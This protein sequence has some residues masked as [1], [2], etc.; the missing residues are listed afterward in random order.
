MVLSW[1]F[2][3]RSLP[4]IFTK[5]YLHAYIEM[6]G[7]S[8]VMDFYRTIID[9]IDIDERIKNELIEPFN[10]YITGKKDTIGAL[11]YNVIALIEGGAYQ[12]FDQ[13]ESAIINITREVGRRWC[14]TKDSLSHDYNLRLPNIL[15]IPYTTDITFNETSRTKNNTIL[16]QFVETFQTMSDIDMCLFGT[17]Y[18]TIIIRDCP[19]CNNWLYCHVWWGIFD[20]ICQYIQEGRFSVNIDLSN[21]HLILIKSLY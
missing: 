15:H 7:P 20:S 18:T 14:S 5:G 11:D 1:H 2:R 21:S 8:V 4:E 19:F 12:V 9:T 13:K 6:F 17:D 16:C 3:G 10:S